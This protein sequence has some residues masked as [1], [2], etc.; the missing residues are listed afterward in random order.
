MINKTKSVSI[1][2]FFSSL[3]MLVS[4]QKQKAEWKGTIEEVDGVTVVKN[5]KE[6]MYGEDVFNVEEELTI[7]SEEGE[8]GFMFLNI[9]NLV[10]DEEENIYV[11]DRKAAHIIVFD[12]NGDFLRTIGKKGQGPG[13]MRY[14]QDIQVFPQR[15]LMVNDRGQARIHFFSLNGE[16]IRGFSTSQLNSF[17]RPKV[18]SHGNMVAVFRI[19]GDERRSVLKKF[20]S[21]LSPVFTIATQPFVSK[22][23]TIEYFWMRRLT[24]LVWN[25]TVE[26]DIIWGVTTKYEIFVL[27][28]EGNLINKIVREYDGIKITEKEKEKLIKDRFGDRPVHPSITLKFP[29]RY[30][31]FIRFTCDEEGRIFVQTYEKTEDGERDYYDVFDSEGKYIARISLK[32]RPMVWKNNKLFTIEED[33]DGFQFVKR[34]RVTWKY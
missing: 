31:P 33:E 26:D 23:P 5:P 15:E 32:F 9:L 24:N 2:L 8:E 3:M 22:P 14:P 6:P 17:R 27:N 34:Y 7:E 1:I 10:V 25:V 12:K 29:N 18:D 13:E 4:C 16:Y 20:T 11:C 19:S 28:T 21:D 30:P